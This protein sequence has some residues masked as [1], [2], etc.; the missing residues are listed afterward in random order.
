MRDLSESILAKLN[1]MNW[2]ELRITSEVA[3]AASQ[4]LR[5]LLLDVE[6]ALNK[7][8]VSDDELDRLLARIKAQIH[9]KP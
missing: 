7:R 9:E 2:T 6:A 3:L 4:D 1:S 8:N 5:D